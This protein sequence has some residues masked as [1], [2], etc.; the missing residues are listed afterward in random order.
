MCVLL[1]LV[2]AFD[3]MSKPCMRNFNYCIVHLFWA[4]YIKFQLYK[5]AVENILVIL[6]VK[7]FN[8][9]DLILKFKR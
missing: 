1:L 9:S 5:Y 7:S 4:Y 8:V 6:S 2:D 3:L